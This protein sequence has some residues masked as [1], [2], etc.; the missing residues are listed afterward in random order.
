MSVAGCA[1]PLEAP[2]AYTGERFLCGPEHAAEF[3]ALSSACREAYLLDASCE[4]F[5]SLRG[6][7]EAQPFVVDTTLAQSFYEFDE[8]LPTTPLSVNA[9][10]HSPY[11]TFRLSIDGLTEETGES[12]AVCQA[13]GAKLIGVEVRGS[14]SQKTLSLK[15]CE[16]ERLPDGIYFAVSAT[17]VREAGSLDMCAYLTEN[18]PDH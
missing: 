10:G 1:T 3:A 18:S 11:F 5:A 14:S 16:I 8:T 12:G 15:T 7:F 13:P 2:S 6:E 17:F 4:G 9:R